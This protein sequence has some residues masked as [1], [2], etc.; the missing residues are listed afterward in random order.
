[1]GNWNYK[2][3]ELAKRLSKDT[4]KKGG[5]EQINAP[6][7]NC[8]V[9]SELEMTTIEIGGY[10]TFVNYNKHREK[11]HKIEKQNKRERSL[12]RQI[13]RFGGRKNGDE[14]PSSLDTRLDSSRGLIK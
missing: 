13:K 10:T 4:I 1:M 6:V 8:K 7:L 9:A 11:Q 12:K 2:S 14:L 3:S 5:V